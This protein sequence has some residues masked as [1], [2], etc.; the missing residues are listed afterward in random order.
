MMAARGSAVHSRVTDAS[1][2]EDQA[3]I[4]LG[5]SLLHS[6][7][8]KEAL[9]CFDQCRSASEKAHAL[10]GRAVALQMLRRFDEAEVAYESLL[11][12]DP[13]SEE[14]LSNLVTL[15]MEVFDMARVERYGQKLLELSPDDVVG[16][17]GLIVVALNRGE[18]D[19]AVLQLERLLEIV[20]REEIFFRGHPAGEPE[21][22]GRE[23][24]GPLVYHAGRANSERLA[25]SLSVPRR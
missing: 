3:R 24:D 5:N 9:D 21:R 6:N 8:P 16:L 15:A 23:G 25:G 12:I 18:F 14:A 11:A 22:L 7:R 20:P 4:A 13:A 2:R 17:Q 19:A 1:A 10:F